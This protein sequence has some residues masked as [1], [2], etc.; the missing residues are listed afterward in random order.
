MEKEYGN[1]RLEKMWSKEEKY[2]QL[3]AQENSLI[4]T[5]LDTLI[6]VWRRNLIIGANSQAKDVKEDKDL[7]HYKVHGMMSPKALST[8]DLH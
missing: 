1:T 7:F 8:A 6:Q 3:N 4:S 5:Q 2:Q